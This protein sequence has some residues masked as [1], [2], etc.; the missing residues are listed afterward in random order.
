MQK[1]MLIGQIRALQEVSG[2]P[3]TPENALLEMSLVDLREMLSEL[4]SRLLGKSD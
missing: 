3:L 4:K 2:V 1:G